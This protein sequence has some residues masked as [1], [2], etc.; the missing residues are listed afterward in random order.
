MG[1]YAKHLFPRLMDRIMMGHKF[2]HLR[3]D[4]LKSA[5]GEV[6]EIGLGTGLNLACYP[7]RVLRLRAVDPAPLLP[8]LVAK[9]CAAVAFPVEILHLSAER[10]PY[11]M[12]VFDCVVSTWTLCTIPD[13]VQALHEIRRVLKP[14]GHLLFLEHGR[15]D[16]ARTAAWQDRLNPIQKVIG[17]GC[18]LN[19]RID[20]LISVA[21]LHLRQL[22][23]CVMAGIPRIAG[24][25]YRG[26]ATPNQIEQRRHVLNRGKRARPLGRQLRAGLRAVDDLSQAEP[27]RGMKTALIVIHKERTLRIKPDKLLADRPIFRSHFKIAHLKRIDDPIHIA[28]QARLSCFD[29]DSCRMC[30]REDRDP[31]SSPTNFFKEGLR[32]WKKPDHIIQLLV[33]RD[34]IHPH[35]FRP[36]MEIGPGQFPFH[37]S[38]HRHQPMARLFERET[39]KGRIATGQLCLEEKIIEM[40]VQQRAIHVEQHVVDVGPIDA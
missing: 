10:L 30:V 22:D 11:E 40:P 25:L 23:R 20:Q 34:H 6:L 24:E 3:E 33:H 39:V 1:L 2:Q 36:I 26:I 19:R 5:Q 12:G 8:K 15:S 14:T 28:I 27:L 7:P 31:F 18:N 21:G 35:P 16:D 4:L 37:R 32:P 17:C 38:I 29:F 9:R 13:P